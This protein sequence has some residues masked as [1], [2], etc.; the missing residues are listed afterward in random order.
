VAG[1]VSVKN[2]VFNIGNNLYT[3]KDAEDICN[4]YGAKL[5]NY[6]NIEKSYNEGG[7]WCNYGWSEGQMIFFPTQKNTWNNLQKNSKTKNNCGRPGVNGGYIDNPYLKFGVNCYGKR[8]TPTSKD[9]ARINEQ[10]LKMIANTSQNSNLDS[11]VEFWKQN[12][13]K[14]LNINSFNN[15]KW[16]QY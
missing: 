5:A 7:E 1:N 9:I 4:S 12:A 10:K 15:E 2:E 6:E 3:Y 16:S 11:K 13:D 8:P 14:I